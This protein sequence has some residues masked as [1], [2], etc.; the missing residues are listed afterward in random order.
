MRPVQ[1]D[2]LRKDV[3]QNGGD[4]MQ[5]G[6]S[7][8]RAVTL[9]KRLERSCVYVARTAIQVVQL[10]EALEINQVVGQR[11]YISTPYMNRI[12]VISQ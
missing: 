1:F 6:L 12:L 8:A 4:V 2:H 7:N 3:P 10:W 11:E 9:D 5:A